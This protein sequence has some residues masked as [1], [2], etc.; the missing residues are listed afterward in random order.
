MFLCSVLH[1]SFGLASTAV[2]ATQ[3]EKSVGL[4]F[5]DGLVQSSIK[6]VSYAVGRDMLLVYKLNDNVAISAFVL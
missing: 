4:S 6:M 3:S 5:V 2:A 1:Q